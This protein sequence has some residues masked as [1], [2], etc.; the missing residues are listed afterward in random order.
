[1]KSDVNSHHVNLFPMACI[2]HPYT[3]KKGVAVLYYFARDE[4]MPFLVLIGVERWKKKPDMPKSPL[5]QRGS[6]NKKRN[7]FGRSLRTVLI[8]FHCLR[9]MARF[10]GKA[11]LRYVH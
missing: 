1:M 2:F 4:A 3:C 5:S 11:R 7:V 9:Q 6:R 8:I 10:C